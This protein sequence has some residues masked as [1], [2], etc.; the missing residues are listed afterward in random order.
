MQELK[1]VLLERKLITPEKLAAA[2]LEQTVTKERLTK[3]LVRNSFVNQ[4]V[5]FEILRDI[6]PNSLHDEAVFQ[7]AVPTDVLVRTRSMITASVGDTLYIGTLSHPELVRKAVQPYVRDHKLVFTAANPLKVQEYLDQLT[8]ADEDDRLTWETIF[9]DAMR[10]RSS[11]IHILPGSHSYTVML[12]IDGLL[13]LKHAGT[14]DEYVAMNSRIKDLSRMDMAERRRP[15]DGGFSMEYAGRVVSFRVATIPGRDGEKIVVR[16]LD[17]DS[18]NTTLDGLG[19]SRLAMWR[20]AVAKPGGL[21][22][23]CG[24]TGSGKTTTLSATLREMNFLEKAI[25]TI[26]DPVENLIPYATQVNKN[27]LVGLTF[28]AAQRSFMRADPDVIVV[29]ELRDQETAENALK[30][31]ETGHLTLA[32]LHTDSIV[33][34]LDRLRHLGVQPHELVHLLRGVLVQRLMRTYCASCHGKGCP[35]CEG[36][37]LK[38]RTVVSEMA[39][40]ETAADVQA[41]IEGKVTW[42][43]I[44]QDAKAKVLAGVTPEHEFTRVFGI[45]LD[46]V[47]E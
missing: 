26:E 12:R 37:G 46:E 5:L 3:I 22:L 23:I 35:S 27:E 6:N 9:H 14:L 36:T 45:S 19:I 38:G 32:T 47:P 11:D 42:P 16:I 24:P 4:R 30:S 31:A 7:N 44:Y 15:Q 10:L 13:R 21:C 1:Q 43:T 2:E 18:A 40:F 29:G 17:P 25:Y 39:V 34:T 41:V 20:R 8:Q 33:V 28:A